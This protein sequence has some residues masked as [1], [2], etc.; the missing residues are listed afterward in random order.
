MNMVMICVWVVIGAIAGFLPHQRVQWNMLHGLAAGVF[1]AVLGGW[2]H[3]NA[4]AGDA[5]Y[6]IV[7]SIGSSIAAAVV[8][9][10]GY[11]FTASLR[12]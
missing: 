6:F 5:H 7:G 1:G 3:T 11:G 10:T 8:V 9:L 2:L 12:S 4:V